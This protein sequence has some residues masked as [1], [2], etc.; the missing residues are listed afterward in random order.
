MRVFRRG[1]KNGQAVVSIGLVFQE[2]LE[3][4]GRVQHKITHKRWPS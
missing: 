3:R 4:E 1:C 2:P